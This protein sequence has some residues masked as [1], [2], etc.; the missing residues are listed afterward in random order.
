MFQSAEEK[1]RHWLKKIKNQI[2]LRLGG[3]AL[4][5]KTCHIHMMIYVLITN[6]HK[7]KAKYL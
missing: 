1:Y 5:G 2:H 7:K 4:L 3:V 6:T